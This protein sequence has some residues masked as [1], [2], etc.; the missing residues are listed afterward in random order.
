MGILLWRHIAKSDDESLEVK[1]LREILVDLTG[2]PHL[3]FGSDNKSHQENERN[4]LH[5]FIYQSRTQMSAT[6]QLRRSARYR[7][8]G[9]L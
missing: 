6:D 5:P 7:S 4:L 9:L 8:N 2:Q 1:N 3:G